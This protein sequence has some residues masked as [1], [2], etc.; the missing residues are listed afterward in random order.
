MQFLSDNG[1]AEYN[2]CMCMSFLLPGLAADDEAGWVLIMAITYNNF[3]IS[4]LDF[5][6]AEA[7]TEYSPPRPQRRLLLWGL[8]ASHRDSRRIPIEM[9]S[10]MNSAGAMLPFTRSLRRSSQARTASTSSARSG[11][12]TQSRTVLRVTSGSV[13]GSRA[14]PGTASVCDGLV[15]S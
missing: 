10:R 2:L 5:W 13:A 9:R 12:N 1:D 4:D 6:R 11:M 3:E 15:F 7:Y 8:S 14:T